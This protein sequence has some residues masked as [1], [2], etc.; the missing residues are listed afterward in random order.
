[1]ENKENENKNYDVKPY[2]KEEVEEILQQV[3]NKLLEFIN[4]DK[5]KDVL[6][7]Y[8]N[9]ENEGIEIHG[10]FKKRLNTVSPR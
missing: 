3:D 6:P 8:K 2:K 1:M 5:Y 7:Y 10:W 9:I 4:S